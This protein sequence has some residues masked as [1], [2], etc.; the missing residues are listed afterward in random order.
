ME[1]QSPPT[2]DDFINHRWQ[3]ARET[4]RSLDP[5]FVNELET[6]V[7]SEGTH[8]TESSLAGPIKMPRQQLSKEWHKLL[9]ACLDL[10][11]QV[12]ILRVPAHALN[13]RTVRQM[14]NDRIV[15]TLDYHI[16]SFL[17]HAKTLAEV[18]DLVIDTFICAQLVASIGNKGRTNLGKKYRDRVYSGITKHVD[19]LRNR[20]VHPGRGLWGQVVTQEQ[21]WEG[22]IAIGFT[23]EM[24][25]EQVVFVAFVEQAKEGGYDELNDVVDVFA[26]QL[27]LI[28]H[29]LE[30]EV[31]K[32]S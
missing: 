18:S 15:P 9:A 31:A 3:D 14:G 11:M 1:E 28:L 25:V 27:G 17:V 30:Q 13:S 21:R 19:K 16:R 23:P 20:I 22:P 8:Q 29:D 4:L 12:E 24:A 32:A 6:L 26:Q 2:I 5:D 7:R 10:T